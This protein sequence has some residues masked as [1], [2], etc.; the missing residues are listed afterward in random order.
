VK[1]RTL[2][3]VGFL[4]LGTLGCAGVMPSNDPLS[5]VP[6]A[7]LTEPWSRMDLPISGGKV[8][9]SDD[10]MVTV[11]YSGAKVDEKLAAFTAPVEKAGFKK[12]MDVSGDPSTKSVIFDKG[13]K[14]LTLTVT[15][16]ADITTVSLVKTG[17]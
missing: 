4:A 11:M 1:F 5:Y 7:T 14:K 17:A 3:A 13:G 16:A 12:E 2:V 6:E 8:T 15:T 10:K 9:Q